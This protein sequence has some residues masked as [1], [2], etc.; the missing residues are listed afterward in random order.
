MPR[1]LQSE[2]PPNEALG[3]SRVR[4]LSLR[5]ALNSDEREEAA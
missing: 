3:H 4:F 1:E 5:P 2:P